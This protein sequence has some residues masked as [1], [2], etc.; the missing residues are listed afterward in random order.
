[1]AFSGWIECF[2]R[3]KVTTVTIDIEPVLRIFLPLYLLLF[4]ASV[5]F[6]RLYAVRQQSGVAV[7]ALAKRQGSN[8]LID[9]AFQVM[10]GLRIAVICVFALAPSWYS[11]LSPLPVLQM[12]E[13]AALGLALLVGSWVWIVTAQSQMGKAWRIGIDRGNATELVTDGVFA[14]SRNPIFLGMRANALGLFLALPNA[15]TLAMLIF[16]ELLLP[17][18]VRYEERHL[19]AL[20]GEAFKAY[21]RKV[22]R[23]L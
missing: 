17:Y 5:F 20:H 19:L 3:L 6:W 13:I 11:L 22:R 7:S 1:M 23:W 4:L 16:G 2:Q 9:L 14:L 10:F 18:H 21:C 12:P 15:L 8:K